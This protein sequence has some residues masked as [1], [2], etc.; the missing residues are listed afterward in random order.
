LQFDL[1]SSINSLA[2]K[3][4]VMHGSSGISNED[5]KEAVKRGIC[6]VNYYTGLSK[7]AVDEIRITLE[8][9]PT[10]KDYHPLMKIG[11]SAMKAVVSSKIKVLGS[12][13]KC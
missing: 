2:S 11:K 13:F 8:N 5:L 6:K 3:P 1:L 12:A 7:A 9:D 10:W 4:L